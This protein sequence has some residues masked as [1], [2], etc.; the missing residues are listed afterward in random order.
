LADGTL[1]GIPIE[2]FPAIRTTAGFVLL[3]NPFFNSM[4]LQVLQFFDKSGVVRNLVD[5]MDGEKAL[6]TGT[7]KFGALEAPRD[8]VLCGA[9]AEAMAAIP[10]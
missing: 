8:L 10:A 6:E 3:L 7:R 1:A 2:Y 4:G 5:D 9:T